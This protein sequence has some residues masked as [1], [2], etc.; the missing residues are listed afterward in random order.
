MVVVGGGRARL[1]VRDGRGVVAEGRERHGALRR[2]RRVVDEHGAAVL[3]AMCAAS[4]TSP[5]GVLHLADLRLLLPDHLKQAILFFFP[6]HQAARGALSPT[7]FI[8]TPG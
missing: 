6:F 8:L 2:R 5:R 1:R 4:A 3:G 7:Q